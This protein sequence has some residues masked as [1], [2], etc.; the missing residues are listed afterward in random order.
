MLEELTKKKL[1]TEFLMMKDFETSA[2][3]FYLKVA[4][5]PTVKNEEVKREFRDIAGDEK[6]HAAIVDKIIELIQKSL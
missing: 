4:S 1:I 3:D 2:R 6:K 5:D